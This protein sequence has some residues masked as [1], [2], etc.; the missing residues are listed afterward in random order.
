MKT[1]SLIT[2]IVPVYNAE[3]Y[4]ERCIS[5]ILNQTYTNLDILLVDDG[6]TDKSGEICDC[7]AADDRIRVLHKKNGG[8]SSARNVALE[9]I[10]G[11]YVTF[12]DSDD[13]LDEIHGEELYKGIKNNDISAVSLCYWK[14]GK[15]KRNCRPKNCQW[16]AEEFF[17][18]VVADNRVGGSLCNKLFKTDIILEHNLKFTENITMSEDMLF[19][20]EYLQFCNKGKYSCKSTYYYVENEDSAMHSM[21]STRKFDKKKSSVLQATEQIKKI[22]QEGNGIMKKGAGYRYARARL[23][24]LIN[25]ICCEFKDDQLFDEIKKVSLHDV[26]DYC[27]CE[28]V[29]IAEKMGVSVMWLNPKLVWQIGTMLSKPIMK[30][31]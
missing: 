28:H 2:V 9:N 6:S 22:A 19:I 25:M 15:V 5:S 3:K 30:I 21:Y 17:Y 31:R 13:F 12:V 10:N 14:N 24:I 20:C 18:Y 8:V 16:N 1:Q 4:L 7:F 29:P 27:S 26:L 23:W 11:D